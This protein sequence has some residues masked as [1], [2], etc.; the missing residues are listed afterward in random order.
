MRASA[1]LTAFPEGADP[2]LA[3]SPIVIVR[4]PPD[5]VDLPPGRG[6]WA[7]RGILA[8]SKTCTHAACA[9]SLFRDPMD[10]QTSVGPALVCPC[11]Y[12]TFDVAR[13]AKPIFG[14]AARALPQLPLRIAKD[15]TLV[16]AGPLSGN[17]GPSWWGIRQ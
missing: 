17:V 11:H 5:T 7:P 10:S 12:S 2:R 3:A 15:G 4:I 9:V 1:F 13:G 14:P 16:A 6:D 8:Y